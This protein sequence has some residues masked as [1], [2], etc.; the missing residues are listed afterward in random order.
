MSTTVPPPAASQTRARLLYVVGL[1]LICVV[2]VL[3]IVSG[4]IVQEIYA[5]FPCPVLVTAVASAALACY[6]VIYSVL[7][8]LCSFA[9]RCFGPYAL[10]YRWLAPLLGYPLPRSRRSRNRG[11]GSPLLTHRSLSSNSD[12]AGA[13]STGAG[14]GLLDAAL[15]VEPVV[16]PTALAIP[17]AAPG[18][19]VGTTNRNLQSHNINSSVNN[20]SA[21]AGTNAEASD[22]DGDDS[23]DDGTSDPSAPES[24]LLSLWEHARLG[25]LLAP[26]WLAMNILYAF[27][28]SRTS[29]ASNTVLGTTSGL[30]VMVLSTIVLRAPVRL[31]SV[32]ACACVLGGA[33]LVAFSPSSTPGSG[34]EG[35]DDS[36][37]ATPAHSLLGDF[38]VILA[39]F[40]YAC[41][42][43]TAEALMGDAHAAPLDTIADTV[44]ATE[45]EAVDA[46]AD[47]AADAA[48]AA[49]A[50][51]CHLP[52]PVPHAR[53]HVHAP[54]PAYPGLS[55]SEHGA[56]TRALRRITPRPR[57][58][59]H[60]TIAL[61]FGFMGVGGLAMAVPLTVL[62]HYTGVQPVPTPSSETITML[63]QYA[64]FGG[65]LSDFVWAQA[66]LLTSPLVATLG[67]TLS[68]P[69]AMVTDAV[70]L[71]TR[72][73]AGY[74]IG[75]VLILV[76]VVIAV[77][78]PPAMPSAAAL[79]AAAAVADTGAAAAVAGTDASA[80]GKAVATV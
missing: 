79:A 19:P 60:V 49:D 21:N 62:F 78:K 77:V 43:L 29:L 3:W 41:Y 69:S 42:S 17:D 75:A 55:Q 14:V 26:L 65:P 35:G 46:A 48:E 45:E 66:M 50:A 20:S 10:V 63:I 30:W 12:S 67:T 47:A 1:L 33:A 52:P 73:S 57:A 23:D 37:A 51:A 76:G 56:F 25:L 9:R 34:D 70:R 38:I 32:L 8:G 13:T 27:A 71:G 2:V 39:A 6:L 44:A 53:A 22:H 74:V 64:C 28:L 40:T 24:G 11:R 80:S 36:G 54:A 31:L 72:F 18:Y 7:A 4:V 15:S 68:T 61:V 5:N 16:D 59:G 58:R